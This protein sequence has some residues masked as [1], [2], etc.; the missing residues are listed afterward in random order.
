VRQINA[1]KTWKVSIN[2]SKAS[3]APIRIVLLRRSSNGSLF[4]NG[5]S[6][7]FVLR[8]LSSTGLKTTPVSRSTRVD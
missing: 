5:F 1:D 2:K 8:N 6:G 4:G 3:A 7:Q